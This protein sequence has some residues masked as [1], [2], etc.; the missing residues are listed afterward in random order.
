ME[1][2][3]LFAEKLNGHC[4][5]EPPG[6]EW[7]EVVRLRHAR[8]AVAPRQ[9]SDRLCS[10]GFHGFAADKVALGVECVVGLAAWAD[11]KRCA[12]PADLNRGIFRSRQRVG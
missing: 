12:D 2:A 4:Q 5:L 9:F 3:K 1:E 11:R 6:R 10:A 7:A 8:A